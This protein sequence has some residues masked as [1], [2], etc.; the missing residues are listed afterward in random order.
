MLIRHRWSGRGNGINAGLVAAFISAHTVDGVRQA[1]L[2]HVAVIAGGS[3]AALIG[4]DGGVVAW[5]GLSAR[6]ALGLARAAEVG[7]GATVGA[8]QTPVVLRRSSV[9]VTCL[10]GFVV[11]PASG[12]LRRLDPSTRNRLTT[13]AELAALAFDRAQAADRER[14]SRQ[15]LQE[16]E[17]QLAEAQRTAGLGSY[18]W[19]PATRAITWSDEMYS[20]LGYEASEVTDPGGAFIERVHPD[21]RARVAAD[22]R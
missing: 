19:E 13:I 22:L 12:R 9:V 6:Q 18:T 8:D 15:A 7:A 1:L 21:D 2:R 17:A 14:V 3:G 20:I 10:G 16:R 5:H 11:A 4:P